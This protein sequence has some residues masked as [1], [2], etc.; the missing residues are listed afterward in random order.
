ML[1]L[2][3]RLASHSFVFASLTFYIVR[4]SRSHSISEFVS[5]LTCARTYTHTH[6]VHSRDIQASKKL[7]QRSSH[8]GP[9]ISQLPSRALH[10]LVVSGFYLPQ[11]LPLV[12]ANSTSIGSPVC[13]LVASKFRDPAGLVISPT[14]DG[15]TRT[16]IVRIDG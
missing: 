5:H 9:A 6:N 14:R 3:S 12:V 8:V 13:L 15:V 1:A 11:L 10:V 4:R 2:R 7:S 16:M